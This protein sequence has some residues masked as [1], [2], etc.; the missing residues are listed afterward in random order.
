MRGV[1]G[2]RCGTGCALCGCLGAPPALPPTRLPHTVCGTVAVP[3]GG[4]PAARAL[5]HHREG[6]VAAVWASEGGA[7]VSG[8]KAGGVAFWSLTGQE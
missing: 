6:V 4:A 1:S 8:D 7:L 3:A 5:R 2:G